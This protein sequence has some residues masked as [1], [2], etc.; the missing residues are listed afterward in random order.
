MKTGQLA[1][2]SIKHYETLHDGDLTKIGLQ[3]KQCPAGIVTIGFGHILTHN[4]EP[5]KSFHLAQ[6]LFPQYETITEEEA[7]ELLTQDLI[8]EEAKIAKHIKVPLKQ[9][10]YDALISY[11][12]NIGFSQT[13]VGLVNEG[14]L[15]NEIYEWF[16]EHYITADGKFMKG[17]L[18]RRQTEALLF[19]SGE[20]K[21]FNT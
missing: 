8:K 7:E 16:T 21:F 14:A 13:M 15:A 2:D 1:I 12:F 19:T 6:E 11:F 18:Y 20:L 3:W 4:G 5:I 10:Q 9:H 17:L